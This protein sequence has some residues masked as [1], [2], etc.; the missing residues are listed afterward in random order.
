M[1]T[2]VPLEES[3]PAQLQDGRCVSSNGSANSSKRDSSSVQHDRVLTHGDR[4]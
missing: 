3:D 4:H 1:I 2:R